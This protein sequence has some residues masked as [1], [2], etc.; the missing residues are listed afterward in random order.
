MTRAIIKW[1]DETNPGPVVMHP[2]GSSE[3]VEMFNGEDE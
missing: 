3:Q 1:L 2:D